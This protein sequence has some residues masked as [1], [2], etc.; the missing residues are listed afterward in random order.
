MVFNSSGSS[1]HSFGDAPE[2]IHVLL[3]WSVY[4]QGIVAL[5]PRNEVMNYRSSFWKFINHHLL[6][7]AKMSVVN[8]SLES[9]I[10]L[11]FDIL[12]LLGFKAESKGKGIHK[13]SR[14]WNLVLCRP[15]SIAESYSE[16]CSSDSLRL[17][18]AFQPKHLSSRFT[19]C[20]SFA[21]IAFCG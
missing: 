7:F 12:I 11:C 13:T 8:H 4:L 18:S 20:C 14:L 10:Q 1:L 21:N 9:S 3:G 2:K 19:P 17:P 15:G 6:G 5:W 16:P